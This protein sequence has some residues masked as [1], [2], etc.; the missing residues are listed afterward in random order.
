MLDEGAS[1]VEIVEAVNM[2]YKEFRDKCIRD[3]HV[4]ANQLDVNDGETNVKAAM[5]VSF[6]IDCVCFL[7]CLSSSLQV[8]SFPGG[9]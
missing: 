9:R 4:Q 3:N 7:L 1:T 5:R 8:F 6:V 2:I